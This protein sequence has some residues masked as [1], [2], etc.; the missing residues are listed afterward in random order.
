MWTG[1]TTFSTALTLALDREVDNYFCLCIFMPCFLFSDVSSPWRRM[2]VQQSHET[3]SQAQRRTTILCLDRIKTH[4]VY[5]R[6]WHPTWSAPLI[7]SFN[8][9][10]L[11]RHP[12][13]Q[14]LWAEQG[15]K[16]LLSCRSL[17]WHPH[18]RPIT[19]SHFVPRNHGLDCHDV[20]LS[21]MLE[22]D[23]WHPLFLPRLFVF[24]GEQYSRKE[25]R[26]T[27][28]EFNLLT[29]LG[30]WMRVGFENK[31]MLFGWTNLG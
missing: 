14:M 9:V 2:D 8:S 13:S 18:C 10:F 16:G 21:A 31:P 23:S 30:C 20:V 1:A 26:K 7:K 28:I 4:C 3:L 5:K 19:E 25:E 17:G 22:P 6:S 15:I 11:L 24:S 12:V 29:C 27:H